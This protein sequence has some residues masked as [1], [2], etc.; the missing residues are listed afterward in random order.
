M[1]QGRLFDVVPS[2]RPA[3]SP[4]PAA[5]STPIHDSAGRRIG[6]V[7]DDGPAAYR[8]V[9]ICEACGMRL[10]GWATSGAAEMWV[11]HHAQHLCVSEQS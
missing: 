3:A 10:E 7:L 4:S 5:T 11:R 8:F 6:T 1:K 2:R 9:G